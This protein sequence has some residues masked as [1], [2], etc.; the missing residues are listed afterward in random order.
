MTLRM[1][2]PSWSRRLLV[3]ATTLITS[4][5]AAQQS[6]APSPLVPSYV[7]REYLAYVVVKLLLGDSRRFDGEVTETNPSRLYPNAGDV[8]QRQ[9]AGTIGECCEVDLPQFVEFNVD[10]K[11]GIAFI[12]ECPWLGVV[13]P[14]DHQGYPW[15]CAQVRR[16]PAR[17]KRVEHKLKIRRNSDADDRGLRCSVERTAG[18]NGPA[19]RANESDEG[20]VIHGT[21]SQ[22]TCATRNILYCTTRLY[23]PSNSVA[24]PIRRN[25]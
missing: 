12:L 19:M 13:P 23:V 1:T 9:A 8:R 21:S 14:T 15:I 4:H 6:A 25:S 18:F 20:D 17:C 16:L 3:V 22:Q 10:R 2:L 11:V 5:V 24:R 7:R